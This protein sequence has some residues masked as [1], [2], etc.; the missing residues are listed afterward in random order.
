MRMSGGAQNG[1]CPKRHAA[2]TRERVAQKRAQPR[3]R[4]SPALPCPAPDLRPRSPHLLA[5]LAGHGAHVHEVAVAAPGAVVLLILPARGLPEVGDGR[6]LHHNGLARVV[7]PLHA[8]QRARGLLLV[9]AAEKARRKQPGLAPS[10][11]KHAA[12]W[13]GAHV[14]RCSTPLGCHRLPLP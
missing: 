5:Q 13:A 8:L 3:Q 4:P 7:A 14:P 2:R 6:E 1:A 9:P 11:A 12:R 10:A